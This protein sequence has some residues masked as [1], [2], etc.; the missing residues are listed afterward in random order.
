MPNLAN[1]TREQKELVAAAIMEKNRRRGRVDPVFFINTF[2]KTF[3]PR[4]EV[5]THDLEFTLYPFQEEYIRD[6][7][8]T[9]R[10]G[11]DVFDEKS[12]D[13]GASWLSLAARFWMW[14]YEPGYQSLL[15]SR[16]EAYVDDGTPASLFG[17]LDYF[18]RHI[19]DPLVLPV[20]FD[21]KKH[22]TY[23]KLKNP[24]NGNMITGESSNSNFS[25][26]GR[27]TDI[28]MDE[29]G[30]WPDAKNSW[31]AAGDATRCR[32]GVTTPPNEPSYAK[33]LRESGKIRVRTWHWRLHPNKDEEWYAYQKQRR[34]EEEMLHEID[35]SWEYSSSGRPYPEVDSITVNRHP[36]DA[37]LPLYAS[38]D[39]GLDAIAV[40][41][42]QPVKNSDWITLVDTYEANDKE[43]EWFLPFFSKDLDPRFTYTDADLEMI[44]QVKYWKPP[45]L[46]GDPSGNQRHVES[47]ISP[48]TIMRN[49]GLP[50][51]VNTEENDWIARRDASKSF[52]RRLRIN[53][54]PRNKWWM[55]CM[56]NARYP[57]RPD[58]SQSTTPIAKPVHDWTSHHRTQFEF[59]SV[60]Y[61]PKKV[62]TKRKQIER[63]RFHV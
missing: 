62:Q 10:K 47:R 57:K 30:F 40:G 9:I 21:I 34:S 15:G 55:E 37:A 5:P 43:I 4:P 2:L 19:R 3:D 33:S 12:R 36:Y 44:E 28:L 27:Y 53:D 50:V 59:F 29:I 14:L 11:E 46:Y 13:M 52:L 60:N 26:G 20:G 6:L 25:R 56:K 35:I 42:Y 63:L 23:M 61:K 58:E 39:L 45:I 51:Q 48:Y 49:N 1:M 41:W 16:K 54:T 8:D 18:I 32:H 7:V 24:A 31:T 17:K 38:I 22:R